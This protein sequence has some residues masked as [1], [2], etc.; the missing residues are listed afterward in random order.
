MKTSLE[1]ISSVKK[2]VIIEIESKEV[3][4]KINAAYR[5]LGQRAKIPGFRPGKIPRNILE[6]RFSNEVAED[7]V[8][9]LINETLPKA[10]TDLEIMPLGTPLLEKDALEKGQE[11]KYSATIEVRPSFEV[12]DYM[13]IEVEK[14]KNAVSEE[15]VA[16]R[17]EQIRQANGDMKTISEDR[18]VQNDDYVELNYDVY[19]GDQSL[20]E[21]KANNFLLKVGSHEFNEQFEEALVG[22]TKNTEKEI[23][24]EFPADYANPKFAGKSFRFI[25]KVIDI[26][27][28][29]VP[30]M[31]DDFA[32]K[33]GADFETLE[34]LKSKLKET[35]INQEE[36]RIDSELRERLLDKISATLDF[37][38]PE[39]LVESELNYAFESFKQNLSQ[40]GANLEM[41]GI[42]EEK[43]R[44]DF[45]GASEMRVKKMLILDEIARKDNVEVDDDDLQKAYEDQAAGMGMQPDMIRQYYEGRGMV[46]SLKEK[47]IG[48]KT[49]KLLVE[50]AKILEVNGEKL[51][52]NETAEKESE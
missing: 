8:R 44:A 5:D 47:L 9:D 6:R 2:K 49:L 1:D 13:G 43:F 39:V 10:I 27:E 4:G 31:N 12:D 7:V 30:E 35:M 23:F 21:L 48:E 37:E 15:D 41:A 52:K 45:R 11:F 40:N 51:K 42:T 50:N 38:Y 18:S 3:D 16:E 14:E 46:D 32:Q 26:K 28:M 19:E 36:Q 33:L 20:D 17:L 34:D 24:A 22:L 29:V 25:A